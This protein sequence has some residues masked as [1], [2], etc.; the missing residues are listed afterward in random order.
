M[1]IISRHIFREF[2][3]LV[4]SVLLG[5]LVVYLCVEFLQKA[6][7]MIEHHATFGQALRYFLDSI[8]GMI[9]FCLPM[10][11]LIGSLLALGGLQRHSELIAM[12]A[13]GM[14]LRYLATPLL[15]AG[16]LLSLIGFLNS[17]FV[18]PA[19]NARAHYIQSVE[20]EKKQQRII[21]SQHQLWL[22]GPDNSIANID[23]VSPNR[24]EMLGLNIFKLNPDFTIRERITARALVWDHGAWRLQGS[25]TFT[26]RGDA[27]VSHPSDGEVFNIVE[28]P[29][30]LGAIVKDSAEMNFTELWDYVR[31]LRNS[32][33]P[34]TPY[35]VDLYGKLAF[36]LSSLLMVMI[37][38]PFSIHGVR[39][40]GAAKGF[41]I[42]LLIAFVYWMLMS[43]GSSLGDSGVLPPFIAAWLAN[44]CF[45]IASVAALVR[46][47]KS[48]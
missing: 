42:A 31:R 38:L 30:D 32:G 17:E 47:Q 23:L 46:L 41:A 43:V 45:G 22:R 15:A 16:A 14:G 40:G 12:R 19:Y 25:R 34:A 1:T 20:I 39:S 33:Y 18:M 36:P 26:T 7:R 2:L 29:A 28:S 13:S 24:R 11:A 6:D 5:I 44:V 48:L 27:V 9:S 4:A 21:F 37:S 35:E 8:P 3:T 10:S